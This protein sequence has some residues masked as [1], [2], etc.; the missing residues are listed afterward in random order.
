[1]TAAPWPSCASASR[2]SRPRGS[3]RSPP[4]RR[5]GRRSRRSP[6]SPEVPKEGGFDAE[7]VKRRVRREREA[8]KEA[9]EGTS[10]AG[11]VGDRSQPFG[12]CDHGAFRLRTWELSSCPDPCDVSQSW[13][14]RPSPR[15]SCSRSPPRRRTPGASA[16]PRPRSGDCTAP[17]T[18]ITAQPAVDDQGETESTDA[19]FRV[20]V[21]GR[22]PCR[23]GDLRVPARGPLAGT[24]LVRLHGRAGH[25]AGLQH[26]GQVL[27]RAGGRRLHVLRARHR[28]RRQPAGHPQHRDHAGDVLV[29]R[30]RARRP[31][32]PDDDNPQ[33]VITNGA[34]RWY[35]FSYLGITYDSD[36]EGVR[37]RCTLNGEDAQL[38][39][40]AGELPRHEGG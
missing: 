5:N 10:D 13:P 16:A 31:P 8:W 36:E 1:M 4:G 35:P 34:T 23:Q 2:P 15:C 18:T 19:D 11:A 40:R 27:H 29:D 21:R 26:R 32:P 3:S 9:A 6:R 30:R 20:R 7:A 22:E 39:R 17:E 28:H 25:E 14:R 33:T 24:H 38:R 37:F 12:P